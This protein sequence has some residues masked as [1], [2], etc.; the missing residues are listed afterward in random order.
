MSL[1]PVQEALERLLTGAHRLGA[2]SLPLADC[3]D[4][5]LAETL[6]AQRTQPPF[7]ASAMDGFAVRAADTDKPGARLRVVGAAPAGHPFDGTVGEGEAVRILTGAPVPEGADSVL[8]QENARMIE[9]GVIE[10]LEPVDPGRNV[11]PRGLDFLEGELLL[12]NGRRLDPAALSLAAAANH[13]RLQVVARPLVAILATGDE[14]R[15]PGSE[16]GPGQ[17]VSSNAYGVAALARAAGARTLDLGIAPDERHAIAAAV[18]RAVS[19]QADVIVTLG[20]ASVGDH[21]LVHDVLT[22]KGAAMDFWKIAMRPGKPL[23]AGRLGTRRI[24]G[25]PGNP[26]A[27]LVC[28]H[29]FLKPL[30]ARLAGRDERPDIR[31]GV[32][33]EPVPANDHRQDYLRATINEEAGRLVA[34]PAPIQDSSM[35]RILADARALIIR[36]PH[37]PPARDG[38]PCR[39][40]MLR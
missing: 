40:L 38:E 31:P 37:A 14:L 3:A 1:V 36:P 8:I 32:L 27:S 21:D 35:L 28:S 22:A 7:N 18:D 30:L 4:R 15:P 16:P 23:M 29:V 26:V 17:I 20:G 6:H 33:A 12:G 10:V 34:T 9:D 25:L 11:R 19:A 13:E 2:E 24:L 39:L 5:I